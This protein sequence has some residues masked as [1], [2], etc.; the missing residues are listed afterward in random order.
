MTYL[1]HL[2]LFLHHLSCIYSQSWCLFCANVSR[3][4]LCNLLFGTKS[5]SITPSVNPW[6]QGCIREM[7]CQLLATKLELQAPNFSFNGY[8][9]GRCG[10]WEAE[11]ITPIT[12]MMKK[13][14]HLPNQ[15]VV[16]VHVTSSS[17]CSSRHYARLGLEITST[18]LNTTTEMTSTTQVGRFHYEFRE[19]IWYFWRCLDTTCLM[20]ILYKPVIEI[21]DLLHVC[22]FPAW[23]YWAGF[24]VS[25][26]DTIA[27]FRHVFTVR[28]QWKPERQ[29][30]TSH[31]RSWDCIGRA[32]RPLV[33]KDRMKINPIISRALV[34]EV[35]YFSAATQ[36]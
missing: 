25:L 10:V 4:I 5:C 7:W 31:T 1:H 18:P 17:E 26:V 15:N 9:S 20:F 36:N 14:S 29:H 32:Y 30:H 34:W 13:E 12:P 22:K 3:N 8:F 21:F 19:T 16:G 27:D 6:I 2:S 35:V 23:T 33:M 28:V 24:H 11:A